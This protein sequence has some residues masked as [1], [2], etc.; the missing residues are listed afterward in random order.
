[1]IQ[2]V[3]VLGAGSAGL[4]AA[5]SLKHKIPTLDVRVVRDPVLGVI[6]VGES[7]TPNLPAYLFD[8]CGINRKFFYATAHPTWKMGIHFLWGPRKFFDFGFSMVTCDAQWS[9][10]PRP[11]GFYCDEDFHDM[12]LC[13]ALMA[14]GKCF[15]RQGGGGGPEIP[16]WHAFH[17]DNPTLVATLEQVARQRGIEFIDAQVKGAERGEAGVATVIL[18]DGRRLEADFYIDASGFRSELLGRTLA[19]PFI[20]FAP[21]LFCDRAIVGS[22][23]RADEPILP[24]TTAETM[25]A[26]WCWQ[27]E[28]EQAVNRGY[29]YCSSALSDEQARNEFLRK[30]PKAR[31]WDHVV[32][33]VSG[34]YQRGWVQNVMGVGN[35]C[36]FVEPLEATALMVVCWQCRTFIDMLL[37]TGMSPTPTMQKL[38][39]DS[40]AATW[41]DIRDFLT[42]HYSTNTRLDNAF[43]LRCRNDADVSR[44]KGLLQFYDEN[45]PTGFCRHLLGT[46]GSQFGAEGYLVI[47]VGNRVPYRRYHP[48]PSEWQIW[49]QHRAR[50]RIAAEAGMDVKE[51]LACVKHPSWRWHGDK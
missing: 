44:V 23:P 41:D 47:L 31:T 1:M 12:D 35:A 9:D 30:N 38:F 29:V 2:S 50:H 7:T 25:D 24:Y 18:G 16:P 17:L 34:R 49:N 39:N 10:L 15:T 32:K 8:Y 20:S 19:E 40:W 43:W 14:R 26:G 28:H 48:S 5:I 11:N 33:F 51:A 37:H 6:G 3:L 36:G 42:L 13:T 21:S 4:I 22:W 27:I 45:G 46:T